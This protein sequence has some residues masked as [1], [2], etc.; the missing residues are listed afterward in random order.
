MARAQQAVSSIEQARLFQKTPTATNTAT[1]ADGTPLGDTDT[2][3]D[4]SFG[5]QVI[6]KSKERVRQFAITGDASVFYTSNVAL[7][8]SGEIGDVF[9]VANAGASWTPRINPHLEA[10]LAAHA[11]IFRYHDT[12]ELDF[13]NVGV[14]AGLF[15]TPE[16][17]GGIGL[18]AHYDFIELLNRHSNE[19]LSDHEFTIGAQKIFSVGRCQSFTVGASAMAGITDPETA[20]RQ[21]VGLF[22]GYH[23]QLTRAL[24]SEIFYRLAFHFY[25]AADRNDLNQVLTWNL[26][27][28]LATWADVNAF[29]SFGNNRSDDAAFDYSVATGGGGIGLTLR[30]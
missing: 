6:L 17:L 10:Q 30:F 19:I 13:E 20:R 16:S 12:S 24:E 5:T 28:R 9:F 23:L 22:F 1:N 21:Q 3:D 11:S 4:D 14:G 25:D 26:R 15:W 18:F 27:Y 2:S 7:T 29:F 8:R